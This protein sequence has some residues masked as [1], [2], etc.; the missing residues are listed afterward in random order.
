MSSKS[1]P[2]AE[3]RAIIDQE[4]TE[5]VNKLLILRSKRNSLAPISRLPPELLTR[6]FFLFQSGR[7]DDSTYYQWIVITHVS[8]GW[9]KLI[10]DTP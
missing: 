9:R 5:L 3:E 1:D 10:L 4:I 8:S 6:I 2:H 7:E